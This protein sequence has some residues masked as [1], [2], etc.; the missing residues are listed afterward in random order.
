MPEIE[1][2]CPT[3]ALML[4]VTREGLAESPVS[5]TELSI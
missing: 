5:V 3:I 4:V 2:N 1:L